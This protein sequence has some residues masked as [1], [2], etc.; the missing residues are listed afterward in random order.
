[1]AKP[2]WGN[3]TF[4]IVAS[5]TL[6]LAVVEWFWLFPSMPD[7][8]EAIA[9][10]TAHKQEFSEL[11]KIFERGCTG[12]GPAE[13]VAITDRFKL[14][15]HVYCNDNGAV[16]LILGSK[17]FLLAIGPERSIGLMYIP[18]DTDRVGPVVP[19]LARHADEVGTLY[20]RRVDERWYVYFQNNDD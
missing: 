6:L 19:V 18:G 2:S 11:T 4:G 17:G 1:M 5:A 15:P 16:R 10:Y 7:E 8:E 14:R 3:V 20:L 13:A 12:P 9:L